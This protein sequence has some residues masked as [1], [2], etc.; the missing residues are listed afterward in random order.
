VK[1]YLLP[2]AVLSIG[3]S[4]LKH[5]KEDILFLAL[6]IPSFLYIGQF[7]K[8]SIHYFIFL[9]P[10]VALFI[11]RWVYAVWN[12]VHS[13]LGRYVFILICAFL[14]L[15]YP[16]YRTALMIR[17]DM[18][19][20]NR[21]AAEKW[22]NEAVPS[23]A[24][25]VLDPLAFRNLIDLEE[26][27]ARVEQ[28]KNAGSPWWGEAQRFYEERSLYHIDSIREIWDDKTSLNRL[29]ADYIAVSYENYGRFY[30]N[31]PHQIPDESSP[32]Y[33]EYLQKKEFYHHLFGEKE[34]PFRLVK[35]FDSIAGPEVKIYK[36]QR[37]TN[38]VVE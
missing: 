2:V 37:M 11:G 12:R 22:M 23:G 17:R 29:Q 8:K 38:G 26:S 13:P 25:I 15:V 33:E 36:N 24:H 10:M 21:I 35:V 34:H 9:Y 19:I 18:M 5:E 28:I 16:S 4:I 30:T 7:E 3:Y 14:F 32:L 27:R 20:D 1:T 31:A 6:V